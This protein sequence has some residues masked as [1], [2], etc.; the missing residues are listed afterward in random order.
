[1]SSQYA[2]PLDP[3]MFAVADG[4]PSSRDSSETS[5]SSG[6]ALVLTSLSFLLLWSV[7]TTGM[8]RFVA[9]VIWD[10]D[11]VYEHM[12]YADLIPILLCRGAVLCVPFALVVARAA[13][14]R[15]RATSGDLAVIFALPGSLLVIPVGH[16]VLRPHVLAEAGVSMGNELLVSV[17][18]LVGLGVACW[19]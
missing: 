5:I 18:G 17:V 4:S 9:P 14:A 11:R 7:A 12:P 19:F 1:M 8:G 6:I 13:R 10:D 2:R 16:V 15:R 3:D